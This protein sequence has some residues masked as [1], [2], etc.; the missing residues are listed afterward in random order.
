MTATAVDLRARPSLPDPTPEHLALAAGLARRGYLRPRPG[1]RPQAMVTALARTLASLGGPLD[2]S[3]HGRLLDTA[4]RRRSRTARRAGPRPDPE[5]IVRRLL[6]SGQPATAA[7][8]AARLRDLR[9]H[10]EAE[11]A[12][13][14]RIAPFVK[15]DGP[16]AAGCVA[17]YR[18]R[19]GHGPSWRHVG[20]YMRWSWSDGDA[21]VRAL[22]SEGWLVTGQERGSLRPGPRYRPIEAADPSSGGEPT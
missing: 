9:R 11:Q 10:A 20:R 6:E 4:L 2:A 7:A 14:L 8:V 22:I 13:S 17:R 12:R 1:T 15:T 19:L 3:E 21:I 16:A 5:R 18:A